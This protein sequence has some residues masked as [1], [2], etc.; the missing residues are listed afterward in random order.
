MADQR[1]THRHLQPA[2]Q[3]SGAPANAEQAPAPVAAVKH[4]TGRGARKQQ[5]RDAAGGDEPAKQEAEQDISKFQRALCKVLQVSHMPPEFRTPSLHDIFREYQRQRGG[6]QI[7]WL[8]DDSALL[9]FHDPYVAKQAYLENVDHA[10]IQVRPFSGAVPAD[11]PRYHRDD[12]Q[13]ERQRPETST[14]TARRMLHH[15]LGVRK[16]HRQTHDT[17]EQPRSSRTRAQRH[18]EHAPERQ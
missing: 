13:Q 5:Q 9:V 6:Y 18:T 16:Q 8:E 7:R 14:A 15:A 3:E 4:R 12:D 1:D 11:A 10:K 2:D 17:S